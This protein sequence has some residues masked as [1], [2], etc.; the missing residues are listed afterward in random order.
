MTKTVEFNCLGLQYNTRITPAISGACDIGKPAEVH[1]FPEPGHDFSTIGVRW[2]APTGGNDTEIF[3]EP[4]DTPLPVPWKPCNIAWPIDADPWSSTPHTEYAVSFRFSIEDWLQQNNWRLFEFRSGSTRRF[5]FQINAKDF[6]FLD[7]STS[8]KLYMVDGSGTVIANVAAGAGNFH[9]AP[10][11]QYKAE[12]RV[13]SL[14]TKVSFKLYRLASGVWVEETGAAMT[15]N[16]TSVS[17]NRFQFGLPADQATSLGLV[18]ARSHIRNVAIW[19]TQNGDGELPG[20]AYDTADVKFNVVQDGVEVPISPNP[21]NGLREPTI[22]QG[23][24]E[25]SLHPAMRHQFGFRSRREI[26]YIGPVA[27]GYVSYR[28]EPTNCR[29]LLYR[30]AGTPPPNGW[31]VFLWLTTNYYVSGGYSDLQGDHPDMLNHLLSAGIAVAA[32]GVS[33]APTYPF[34]APIYDA[35]LAARVLLANNS[36]LDP[37]NVGIGGHSSGS[38]LG[39]SAMIS[40]ELA[41]N[42]YGVDLRLARPGGEGGPDPIFKFAM[43]FSPPV[44]FI[45]TWNSDPTDPYQGSLAAANPLSPVYV[46]DVRAAINVHAGNDI[47]STTPPPAGLDPSEWITM[48]AHVKPTLIITSDGD[49]IVPKWN[50]EKLHAKLQAA[51]VSSTL[52]NVGHIPHP[53]VTH[54]T[55]VE[56]IKTWVR[57]IVS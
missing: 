30:P 57:D 29:Y 11:T 22:V 14:A 51:G 56:T 24:V 44:D 41:N 4:H 52:L 21:V 33:L 9:L 37:A 10:F 40:R 35:K 2:T 17:A 48:A 12:I 54:N 32:V 46:G 27:T 8:N 43:V 53:L 23:G 47:A 6:P 31:P 49:W 18:T 13:K 55:W 42:G 16:P 7:D 39:L 26:V 36:D 34:P 28:P 20:Y 38:G 25:A 5:G 1:A 19:D 45:R 50:A 3:L 15:G